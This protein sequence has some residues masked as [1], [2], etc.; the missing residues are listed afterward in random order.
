MVSTQ[1][2]SKRGSKKQV[3][4]CSCKYS[5]QKVIAS[6]MA[7]WKDVL[8]LTTTSLD[9]K[10]AVVKTP[11]C[12]AKLRACKGKMPVGNIGHLPFREVAP[13]RMEQ[14]T[15]HAL[16]RPNPKG[17]PPLLSYVA[18]LGRPPLCSCVPTTPE[19]KPL[20]S[21]GSLHSP[22]HCPMQTEKEKE[23]EA[24]CLTLPTEKKE[25]RPSFLPHSHRDTTAG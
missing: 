24:S 5:T 9:N 25:K 13:C 11:L 17:W 15:T 1:P 16:P 8:L 12:F 14:W 19:E 18:S 20:P 7:R 22:H 2:A 6:E 4:G 21:F 23:M 3:A 10:A